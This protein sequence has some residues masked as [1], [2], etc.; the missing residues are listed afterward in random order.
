[1]TFIPE[2]KQRDMFGVA[3]ACLVVGWVV[4]EGIGSL[5]T[6]LTLPHWFHKVVT[7]L[8]LG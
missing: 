7:F 8:A 4:T 5:E 3:V 2:L 6:A 1:M